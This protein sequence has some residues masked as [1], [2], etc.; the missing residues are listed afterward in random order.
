MGLEPAEVERVVRAGRRRASPSGRSPSTSGTSGA[1]TTTRAAGDRSRT[2][3]QEGEIEVV[4]VLVGD[5]QPVDAVGGELE[6]R[7][8]DAAGPRAG[9]PT[10]RRRRTCRRS[11]SGNLPGRATSD[12]GSVAEPVASLGQPLIAPNNTMIYL[13]RGRASP[14]PPLESLRRL[15]RTP[16]AARAS[17]AAL[18][19]PAAPA[20][21]GRS[22]GA[23]GT[24]ARRSLSAPRP[25]SRP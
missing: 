16:E 23:A 19:I 4:E 5:Q 15:R 12:G 13:I 7:R 11:R 24:R 9:S 1:G 6:R 18:R 2:V 25:M 20:Q 21:A 8:R 3:R 17:L 14:S 22:G 10:G